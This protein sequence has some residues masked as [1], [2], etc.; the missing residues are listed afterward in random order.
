MGLGSRSPSRIV[1]ERVVRARKPHVCSR[2]GNPIP[3][4][5]EYRQAPTLPFVRPERD[6]MAC[7]EKER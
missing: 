4:G 2:C 7:V 5:A 1:P 3:K 6:C